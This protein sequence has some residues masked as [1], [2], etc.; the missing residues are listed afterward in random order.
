MGY[1]IITACDLIFTFILAGMFGGGIGA[2]I[3]AFILASTIVTPLFFV[4]LVKIFGITIGMFGR[5]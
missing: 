1:L 4:A 5:K 3:I 2:F